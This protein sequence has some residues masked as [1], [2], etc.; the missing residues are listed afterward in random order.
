MLHFDIILFHFKETIQIFSKIPTFP[1]NSYLF[2]TKIEEKAEIPTPSTFSDQCGHPGIVTTPIGVF[3]G[4]FLG[5]QP[6][7]F[8]IFLW[9]FPIGY[10]IFTYTCLANQSTD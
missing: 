1:Q 6:N 5:G 3:E 10:H 9:G 2:P 7:Y 4:V 8:P